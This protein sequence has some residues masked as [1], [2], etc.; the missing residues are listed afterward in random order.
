MQQL[1]CPT[2]RIIAASHTG[3][4]SVTDPDA[5]PN[6]DALPHTGFPLPAEP[7]LHAPTGA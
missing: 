2:L 7:D 4:I 1:L 5:H 3:T 6:T